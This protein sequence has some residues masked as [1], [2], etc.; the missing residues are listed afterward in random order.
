M[1][2]TYWYKSSTFALGGTIWH[3]GSHGLGMQMRL[4]YRTLHL[5]RNNHHGL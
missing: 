3:S 2:R 1:I 5:R 4:G